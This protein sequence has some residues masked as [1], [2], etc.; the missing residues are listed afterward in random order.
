[1]LAVTAA[2]VQR[3]ARKYLDPK[4]SA[5]VWSV[6]AEGEKAGRAGS[7]P[8]R[9]F[10][11]HGTPGRAEKAATGVD[12][13]KTRRV[14]LPNGL[15]VLLYEDHRL[16][17]FVAGASLRESSIYQPDTKLG[18]ARLTGDLLDEGTAKR[19]GAQISDAIETV[20]GSLSLSS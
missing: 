15:V 2:D 13:K 16:P 6:P 8:T 7:T 5:T 4:R 17:L 20:G 12:L 18:V 3:V 1:M 14:E 19:T 11:R 10:A 9:T